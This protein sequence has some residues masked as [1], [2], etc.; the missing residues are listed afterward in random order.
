MLLGIG[1]SS[2]GLGRAVAYADAGVASVAP[3]QFH[4]GVELRVVGHR[5]GDSQ[6]GR[7]SGSA[8]RQDAEGDLDGLALAQAG[9]ALELDRPTSDDPLDDLAHVSVSSAGPPGAMPFGVRR[10]RT[11]LCGSVTVKPWSS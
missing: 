7:I 11:F 2:S 9:I 5:A 1:S 10:G 6:D 8:I 3:K 4:G